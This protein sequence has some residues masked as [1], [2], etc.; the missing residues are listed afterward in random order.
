MQYTHPIPFA[1]RHYLCHQASGEIL[2]DGNLDESDWAEAPWTED[3]VD[4]QGDR[5]PLPALRTRAE[6]LWDEHYL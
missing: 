3:F 2:I 4:I 1:P 6:M 5:Q